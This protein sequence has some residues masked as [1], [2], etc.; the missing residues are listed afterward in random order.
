MN[1]PGL[2]LMAPNY[3]TVEVWS[4][5]FIPVN[6]NLFPDREYAERQN[7]QAIVNFN[8]VECRRQCWIS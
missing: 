2:H 3:P 8:P 4:Y 1:S 7:L 5:I 6:K